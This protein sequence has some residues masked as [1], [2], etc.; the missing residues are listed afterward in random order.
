M[1]WAVLPLKDFVN[2]KQRLSGVLAAH[3]RRHLFHTMVEDV[4]GV[5]VSH[6]AI[7]QVLIVS[8]DPSAALLAEHYGVLCWSESSLAVK[9]LSAVVDA[10]ASQLVAQG[11]DAMLVVHGDLPLL[12]ASD[13]Q[14]LVDTHRAS[15]FPAISIAPDTVGDGSNCVLASPPNAISFQYGEASF[16]KHRACAK[17]K[18]ITVNSL[19][20]AGAAH[21]IDSPDDLQLLLQL[22]LPSQGQGKHTLKYLGESGIA[23]RLRSMLQVEHQRNTKVE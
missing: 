10:A 12:S 6:P 14:Q 16:D 20:L 9:G 3:E 19:S 5:L 21:D 4:L 17:A 11:V 2:A 8:D 13:I 1:V 15:I 22:E 18:F 23:E 7:K